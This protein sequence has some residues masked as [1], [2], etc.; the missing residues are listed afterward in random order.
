MRKIFTLL[1]L[2]SIA[3]SVKAQIAP[4]V[5]DSNQNYCKDDT[6]GQLRAT[7]SAKDTLI[8]YQ[9]STGSSRLPFNTPLVSGKYYAT[10]KGWVDTLRAY[11]LSGRPYEFSSSYITA[12]KLNRPQ[13]TAIDRF[14][15][16]YFL[17]ESK[18]YIRKISPTGMVTV[19]AG[20][21]HLEPWG[22]HV[23]G[24]VDAVGTAARFGVLDGITVDFHGNVYVSD[25]THGKIK[26]IT[27][28][29]V[30]TTYA[31][32][33]NG[34]NDGPALEAQ[35]SSP[36]GLAISFDGTL[37]VV[38]NN[39]HCIRKIE[40]N[41]GN[42]STLAG[43]KSIYN[44]PAPGY[45]NGTGS[46]AFFQ[47]PREITIDTE[48]NLYV[49]DQPG[50][51]FIRKITPVGEVSTYAGS[52]SWFADGLA[53]NARFGNP[54]GLVTDTLG[55]T[56]IADFGNHAIRKITS[57]GTV[58]T[59]AGGQQGY[60]D[61]ALSEARFTNPIAIA[62]DTMGNLYI[63]DQNNHMIRKISKT[64]MVSTIAGL[65]APWGD[66]GMSGFVDGNRQTAQFNSPHGITVSKDGRTIMVADLYNHSIRQINI[67]PSDTTVI[68][69]AGNGNPGF[70][71]NTIG[72]NAQFNNPTDVVLDDDKVYVV[73]AN[74]HRIRQILISP[75]DTTVSTL[76]GIGNGHQDGGRSS[77]QFTGL[78]RITQDTEGNLFVSQFG[79]SSIRKISFVAPDSLFVS[80]ISTYLNTFNP[81]GIGVD[82]NGSLL[83][84]EHHSN[85]IKK[86]SFGI[87]TT[88][89]VF[90]GR[91]HTNYFDGPGVS[92]AFNQILGL[93]ADSLGN[94]FVADD[95]NHKI[96]KIA[97]TQMVSTFAG[98]GQ[99]YQ[100][101]IGVDA[102]FNHPRGLSIDSLGNLYMGEYSNSVIRKVSTTTDSV[103]TL[104]SSTSNYYDGPDSLAI[105]YHPRN[106]AVDA[107]G[108]VYVADEMNHIIRKITP[109]G[110]TTTLAGNG[111]AGSNGTETVS[112]SN[113]RFNYPKA[114]AIDLEGNILVADG[115]NQQIRKIVFSNT[116]DTLV[117]VVAG[118]HH[119]G[120]LVDGAALDAQF[121]M[122]NGLA[123]DSSG[124]I[125]V[126]DQ[127]SSTIR[128]ITPA[129]VVS[130]FAGKKNHSHD[131][132][133]FGQAGYLD[134]EASEAMF[135][136]PSDIA[137]D[138]NGNLYVADH[139]NYRI[140]KIT[141]DGTVS[142]I[143][144]ANSGY[145]LDGPSFAAR[146]NQPQEGVY[147]SQGN[148]FVT[149]RHN[150][151]IRK[152]DPSGNVSTFAGSGEATFSD[153]IGITA[154]F[155]EPVGITID[156]NDNLY[157]A[158]YSNSLIR[159]ITPS[160]VVT[161]FAGTLSWGWPQ[162]GF[163]DSDINGDGELFINPHSIAY[164]NGFLY[165]SDHNNHR[166]RKI[167]VASS[168]TTTIAGNGNWY[169][170]SG[171][172]DLATN[173]DIS[174]P[175]GIAVSSTGT[176]YF[177][178]HFANTI[179]KI[180]NDSIF[181]VAGSGQIWWNGYTDGSLSNARFNSI[182][183]ISMQGDTAILVA[184]AGNHVIRKI[185][186]INSEVSTVAGTPYM[187]GNMDGNKSAAALNFPTA[188]TT[189]S[190]NNLV[191]LDRNNH[192]IRKV[193]FTNTGDTLVSTI[194]GSNHGHFQNA[195]ASYVALDSRPTGIT[196]DTSGNVYTTLPETN[197]II[198]IKP[199]NSYSILNLN[200]DSNW[201]D[202]DKTEMKFNQ[203]HGI[204][205]DP[206]GN[207]YVA[208][209]H[210]HK[211]RKVIQQIL[212]ETE[213]TEVNVTVFNYTLAID[214]IINPSTC[215]GADGSILFATNLPNGTHTLNYFFNES[216]ETQTVTVL[217]SI[218]TFGNLVQ[219][220]YREFSVTANGCTATLSDSTVTLS[221]PPIPL[222][223]ITAS[224]HPT[225]C[226]G[227]DGN[228]SFTVSDVADGT[229]TISFKANGLDTTA[230]VDILDE[231]FT[232]DSLKQGNYS[233]FSILYKNC[234][235][236]DSTSLVTL[237]DPNP[238]VITAG[239]GTNPSACGNN[240]GS[241][242]FTVSN[243]ING[244]HLLSFSFN[245]SPM[246]D[247]V[248]VIGGAFT[249]N[250]LLE[251]NYKNFNIVYRNCSDTDSSTVTLSDPNKPVI[252]KTSS[253]DPS[254][255]DGSDGRILLGITQT[256]DGSYTLTY[257]ANE[258]NASTTVT[259]TSGVFTLGSLPEGKYAHFSITNTNNC[260]GLDTGR[261][262]LV[263]PP[264]PVLELLYTEQYG[265]CDGKEGSITFSVSNTIDGLYTVNYKKNT[266]NS[267]KLVHVN[268]GEFTI[269]GLGK[270]N[271]TLFTFTNQNGC[272]TTDS[273]SVDL[274]DPPLP[275]LSINLA[276]SPST[277]DGADGSIPFTITNTFNGNYTLSFK[278][279][280]LE[281]SAVVT[282]SS[283]AFTLSDLSK[284]EYSD[285][286]FTNQTQCVGVKDSIVILV[287]PPIPVLTLGTTNQ[288]S[289]CDRTDG[290]I[291][292][293][294]TN[295]ADGEYVLDYNNSFSQLVTVT[296]GTF[297]LSNLNAGDFTNFI[298]INQND[299]AAMS[300][301]LVTLQDPPLPVLELLDSTGPST[302]NGVDGKIDFSISNVVNGSY[303]INFKFNAIDST[304]SI[305][306]TNGLF[307]LIGLKEGAYG[308]FSF[309]YN[310]CIAEKDSTV[311]LN[312]PS[313]PEL[314]VNTVYNPTHCL[315][316]DGAITFNT[317]NVTNGTYY[318]SFMKNEV[319]SGDSVTISAN[320]FTLEDLSSGEYT[321]FTLTHKNCSVTIEYSYD[322]TDPISPEINSGIIT[323]PTTCGGTNG[324]IAFTSE[325]LPDMSFTLSYTKDGLPASST[326][327]VSTNAFVLSNLSKGTYKDFSLT[328]LGCTALHTNSKIL[329]EPLAPV[330]TLGTVANPTTCNGTNGNIGFTVT[331]IPDNTYTLS[332]LKDNVSAT[333]S[334]SVISGAFTLNN[335]GRGEYKNFSITHLACEGSL[336]TAVTLTDPSPAQITFS[337]KTDISTC[338][339]T[340]GSIS[341]TTLNLPNGTY[342]LGFLKDDS[343]KSVSITV[344]GNAF[345]LTNLKKGAYKN[346]SVTHLSCE[347]MLSDVITL[348]EPLSPQ[349]TVGT[350]THPTTCT[351]TNGSIPFTVVNAA[352]GTYTLSYTKNSAPLTASITISAGA[353]NLSG[354]SLGTYSNFSI[355][356]RSGC[357]GTNTEIVNLSD[358]LTPSLTA[359]AVTN[360]TLCDGQNGTIAFTTNLPNG[361]YTLD[362][363][364]NAINATASV[365]VS[366]GAFSLSTLTKGT[367]TA[368]SISLNG[369]TGTDAASKT[370]S[371]PVIPTL[372]VGA[373]TNPTLCSN[374]NGNIAFTTSLPAGSHTLT[375]RKNEV[376]T[377]ASIT[378]SS[379][380]FS[381]TGLGIGTYDGFS[382]TL[383][384][385]CVVSSTTSR[386][387]TCP[388]TTGGTVTLSSPGDDFSSGTHIKQAS[389]T[390]GK[391]KATNKV[392]STAKVTYEAPS[393]E[394]LPGFE[395]KSG[396]VFRAVVGGCN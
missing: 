217:D 233:H 333:A 390:N 50:G 177:A 29:G 365:T 280:D 369:C 88:F 141:P 102:M 142:T 226:M 34:Y 93:A 149:D 153:G 311:T 41:G 32:T 269:G 392:I 274:V 125:Y 12:T 332:Y 181:F 259:V 255:C 35:F 65:K 91:E 276:S 243:V 218:L 163:A 184:D 3:A 227:K 345:S 382:I 349:L 193:S 104:V 326:V 387:L 337:S 275:V 216:P 249:L 77:A 294:L 351:G 187:Q 48:G 322:L 198:K 116:E 205:V 358:P 361:T 393:I 228:I 386:N 66:Y 292:F 58:S 368:F 164:G 30:V 178:D 46:Q 53:S 223:T 318:L 287:D 54:H 252:S 173:A 329:T 366:G 186:L 360:P 140:R 335:L 319:S 379:G 175:T 272:S 327:S 364:K 247:S 291:Q 160:A 325:N 83:V 112:A 371:D 124:N 148:L 57:G 244:K 38:D 13:N 84:S 374:V 200:Y 224:S 146:L 92:A 312:D 264:L 267:S 17:E 15:N 71:D 299:C 344:A 196:V 242:A 353:F 357:T 262:V 22:A 103:T 254:T 101:G 290:S 323:Q 237:L 42:V 156:E 236:I 197:K 169:N 235:G 282:V 250:G 62:R 74:N 106:T 241:I 182:H 288:P 143:M 307:S 234:L 69:L 321:D 28:E 188:V 378:V 283:G 134:G 75:T 19:F 174:N 45:K 302:C 334:V 343:V 281:S 72:A 171:D 214:T 202:G 230:T 396:T 347:T 356:N 31:G 248:Q 296:S 21:D 61:G 240:D 89:T 128:K 85:L 161:T 215:A 260:V 8:W 279:D 108:N 121:N 342:A 78:N 135:N 60:A 2:C 253:I 36:A 354:L 191:V 10:A 203:P 27:P 194:A 152:I 95:H 11:T 165:V 298:L 385:N 377:T 195:P 43:G 86:I 166:I 199:D 120:Y 338:N 67:T 189:D 150:H 317:V 373:R 313:S 179:R 114:V 63:A 324:S 25:Q 297:T 346:F 219:G 391:I 363:K 80:T 87:D 26:K 98:S 94:I 305:N 284:G 99:G 37:Y 372:T 110:T 295:T 111:T 96:R 210:N 362:Y 308:D 285:F 320:A 137:I 118:Y 306:I 375:Y 64:G 211:I 133:Y 348:A 172:G 220:D 232:I 359:G 79:N 131:N 20:A 310:D 9:T 266:A 70:A 273:S 258:V 76:A 209:Y 145:F 331:N 380:A 204:S 289:G 293:T 341:F 100:D 159:K 339:G 82:Q 123:V 309:A 286:S 261:T 185:D 336:S 221:D 340:N 213:R 316:Q 33:Y 81:T 167:S 7:V 130:T 394:L 238:P 49:S 256:T 56:Y 206:T 192:R 39:N 113:A 16:I 90:A 144:G 245:N 263:D 370:L 107:L 23:S 47:N 330:L 105:F 207:L 180:Q 271:Y 300:S 251:G 301:E 355:S 51:I 139:N 18:H 73:D 222:N 151:R 246:T 147:D 389:I 154:K 97:P 6:V 132:Y 212:L 367:Y 314:F 231:T 383:G 257:K 55:N 352:N 1:L 115:H 190:E 376:S 229:H 315:G 239:A 127:S 155:N 14:G 303:N 4:P 176:V 208:D 395:V 129:G 68:T 158:D 138:K 122:P 119:S 136:Y 277:C 44:Y 5:I 117:T 126:A 52:H 109:D 157:V 59:I 162:G 268:N 381:L 278:K 384:N 265:I 170:Y 350:F 24:D 168:V 40:P 183:Q 201:A 225:T 388:C 328:Y 304:A 270:G